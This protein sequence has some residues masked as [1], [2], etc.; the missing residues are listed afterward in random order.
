MYFTHNLNVIMYDDDELLIRLFFSVKGDR[1]KF[2]Q[3]QHSKIIHV[4]KD[5]DTVVLWSCKCQQL[6]ATP[7]RARSNDLPEK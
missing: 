5:T 4:Q 1:V 7:G 6:Q 3:N 2:E